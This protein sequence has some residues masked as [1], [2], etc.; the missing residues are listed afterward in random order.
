[1]IKQKISPPDEAKF[2]SINHARHSSPKKLGNTIKQYIG[3]E[4]QAPKNPD[5]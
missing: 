2:N 3:K 5:Q 1:M 4:I